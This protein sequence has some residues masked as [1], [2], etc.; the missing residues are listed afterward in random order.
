MP[1]ALWALDGLGKPLQ[2]GDLVQREVLAE[3]LTANEPGV[4]GRA[5]SK[6]NNAGVLGGASRNTSPWITRREV[7]GGDDFE[8]GILM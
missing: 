2:S 8:S 5:S 4:I 7:R 3:W 6:G 1:L